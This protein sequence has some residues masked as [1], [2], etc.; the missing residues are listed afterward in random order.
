MEACPKILFVEDDKRI[1]DATKKG[2][3]KQGFEVEP[4]YDGF[5]GARLATTHAYDLILLDINL[6]LMNGFEVC[7]AIRQHGV[8]TPI[9]MLTALG[10]IDDRVKGLDYGADDYLVKPFDYR[11]LLARVHALLRRANP[12]HDQASEVLR[13]ANLEMN[14]ISKTV[15][16]D[17][18]LIDLTAREY[19]L[20]EFLLRNKGRVLSKMDIIEH[21]WELNFDTNTNVIEVY[22]NYLRKKIDRNFEPKLIHTKT[23]LGYYLKAD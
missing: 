8:T 2:L 19:E 18:Q 23:G 12:T 7:K 5:V 21:V 16:R 1:S 20:L 13:E 10:E 14:L 3:Q 6:P 15:R 17:N 11:E 9:L 4:A 22:I